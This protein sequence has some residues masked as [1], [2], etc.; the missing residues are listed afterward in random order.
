MV[1]NAKCQK[2]L[3]ET[4]LQNYKPAIEAMCGGISI[5]AIRNFYMRSDS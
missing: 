3:A 1:W 5:C 4:D 2:S